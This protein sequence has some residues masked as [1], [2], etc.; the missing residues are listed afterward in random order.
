MTELDNM[1]LTPHS[2]NWGVQWSADELHEAAT[3]LHKLGYLDG[4]RTAG[5]AVLRP[6]LTRQGEWCVKHFD[7]AARQMQNSAS[8]G[9]QVAKDAGLSDGDPPGARLI[10]TTTTWTDP[11]DGPSPAGPVPGGITAAD[12]DEGDDGQDQHYQAERGPRL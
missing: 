8:T 1:L 4:H 5:G 9:A 3:E 12:L 11:P 6:E 2:W 7:G 10:R